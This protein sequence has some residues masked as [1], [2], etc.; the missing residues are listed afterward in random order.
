MR[1]NCLKIGSHS[2]DNHSVNS[3]GNSK[4]WARAVA[5][6]EYEDSIKWCSGK[7]YGLLITKFVVRAYIPGLLMISEVSVIHALL[8]DLLS[9]CSFHPAVVSTECRDVRETVREG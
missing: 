6:T 4:Q 5:A 7:R 8:R 1:Y 9:L 3:H 2:N